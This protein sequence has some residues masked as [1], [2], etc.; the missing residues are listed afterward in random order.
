MM[1]LDLVC[2][3]FM[4]QDRDEYSLHDGVTYPP[5]SGLIGTESIVPIVMT[6]ENYD[7]GTLNSSNPAQRPTIARASL[8]QTFMNQL[9]CLKTY[10]EQSGRTLRQRT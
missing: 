6:A 5:S 8:L 2:I 10:V 9:P 3:G 4:L 1:L 7:Q